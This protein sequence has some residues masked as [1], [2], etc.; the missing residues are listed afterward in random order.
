MRSGRPLAPASARDTD[1]PD[2]FTAYR[3]A[4]GMSAARSLQRGRSLSEEAMP[5]SRADASNPIA[6]SP[7]SPRVWVIV[8][9]RAGDNSQLSALADRLGWPYEVKRFVY[10]RLELAT[11]LLFDATLLGRI[12]ARSSSLGPPWPDLV[13]SAGRRSEPIARWIRRRADHPVKLVHVGRPWRDVRAFDL[14]VA[15][16]QYPIEPREGVLRNPLP[17]HGVTPARLAAA[18]E[19]WRPRFSELPR[20]WIAVLAG[21]N[22]ELFTLGAKNGAR[23]GREASALAR[24]S[25]GSLLVTT[26]ARTPAA[27]SRALFAHIDVPA[28]RFGWKPDAAENPYWGYLA[29]A[30]A[31]VVTGES[32]S[33]LAEACATGKPVHIFD[34]GGGLADRPADFGAAFRRLLQRLAPRLRRDLRRIHDDLVRHGAAVV[35]GE[36]VAACR[37]PPRPEHVAETAARVRQ[38]LFDP[39]VPAS[40]VGDRITT[41]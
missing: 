33:M 18:A 4:R 26:S 12:A 20:P 13:L 17:L 7:A 24:A 38:L 14:V 30:D 25:G 21:G 5:P 1:A 40:R 37:A 2:R 8:G 36:R 34:P 6:P 19:R 11:N 16:P 22:S 32:A 39:V 3:E 23:L 15:T 31:F 10:R 28:H 27:G 9:Q 29:L 41:R 35:M